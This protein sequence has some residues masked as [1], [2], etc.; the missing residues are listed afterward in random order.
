MSILNMMISS[1]TEYRIPGL[2]PAN[3]PTLRVFLTVEAVCVVL[4]TMD[5]VV[6]LLTVTA[7]AKTDP[8]AGSPSGSGSNSA[9]DPEDVGDASGPDTTAGVTRSRRPVQGHGLGHGH[10]AA[11]GAGDPATAR[12]PAGSSVVAAGTG[13]S[14]SGAGAGPGATAVRRPEG[15]P[16]AARAGCSLGCCGPCC[17]RR[18]MLPAARKLFWFLV[19][20]NSFIDVASFVPYWVELGD[21]GW[22]GQTVDGDT[23][24]L[25][26]LRVARVLQLVKVTGRTEPFQVLIR[27]L[28]SSLLAFGLMLAY[29]CI[30]AIFFAALVFYFESG[31]YDPVLGLWVRRNPSNSAFEPTPFRSVFSGLWYVVVT[32]TTTGYG[33]FVPTSLG[34]CPNPCPLDQ[35]LLLCLWSSS[36]AD[37]LYLLTYDAPDA[38][39]AAA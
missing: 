39:L 7:T 6:R 14:S 22:A 15:G 36:T 13:T 21:V 18:A 12:G 33:D 8:R 34:A 9:D 29:L 28:R 17:V 1:M 4:F 26:V 5:F 37:E 2:L 27:T 23:T 19:S 10:T 38:A 32:V 24:I 16:A 25:R 20:F 11:A 30:L 3:D 35:M 31:E